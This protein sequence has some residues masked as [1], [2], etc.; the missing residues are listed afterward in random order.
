MQRR[1]LFSSLAKS[2]NKNRSLQEKAIRPP[3]FK[4]ESIFF[5]NC[6]LVKN[7]ISTACEENIIEIQEDLLQN[8]ILL[9]FWLY[10]L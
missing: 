7:L 5:T 8:L 3:Y 10:L 6:N 2:F 4:D 1:E 9:Q